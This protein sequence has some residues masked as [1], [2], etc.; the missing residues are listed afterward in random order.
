MEYSEN[1]K[2]VP[3]GCN[4][5]IHIYHHFHNI[6]H[7]VKL[8]SIQCAFYALYALYCVLDTDKYLRRQKHREAL[9]LYSL[10]FM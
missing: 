8:Y 6:W 10:N 5:N 2:F 7:N 3:F 4:K 9:N 1:C